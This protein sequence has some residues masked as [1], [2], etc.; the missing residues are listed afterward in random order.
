MAAPHHGVGKHQRLQAY[1][2]RAVMRTCQNGLHDLG[3]VNVA[4]KGVLD[5]GWDGQRAGGRIKGCNVVR[6]ARGR[7]R[8]DGL[9]S[10]RGKDMMMG[11]CRVRLSSALCAWA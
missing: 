5:D 9:V 6:D 1:N 3:D 8:R 10:T 2:P 7:K 4:A 11:H